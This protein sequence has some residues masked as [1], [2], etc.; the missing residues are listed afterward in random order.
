MADIFTSENFILFIMT[1]SLHLADMRARAIRHANA[2][3]LI[4]IFPASP[5]MVARRLDIAGIIAA[6][7]GAIPPRYIKGEHSFR[8]L[9]TKYNML[10]DTLMMRAT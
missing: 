6:I 4:S 7:S 1:I 8:R 10:F 9:A 5:P 3:G 2:A